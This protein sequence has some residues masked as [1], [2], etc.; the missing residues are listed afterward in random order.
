MG[1][2]AARGI[3]VGL[4]VVL[5]LLLA[6]VLAG[7]PLVLSRGLVRKWINTDPDKFL[8]EYDSAT[9]W[10]PGMV[11]VRGLRIRARDPNVEYFF[12]MEE[13]RVSVSLL[14]L[15]A[16]RFHATHVRGSGLVFRLR[17]RE[18]PEAR[19]R[20][21]EARLPSIPGY[22]DPPLRDSG[23]GAPPDA[24]RPGKPWAVVVE[25]LNV[26]PASEIW[27]E[28]YRFR[29]HARVT[30][31]FALRPRERAQ[32]APSAVDFVSGSIALG[33]EP[34]LGEARGRAS[35]T[36]DPFDPSKVRGNEVWPYIS[37]E[38]RIAGEVPDLAF[39]DHFL[40]KSPEPRLDGGRGP[41]D[42]DVRVEKGVGRGRVRLAA[43][44][45][46][47]RYPDAVIR[48]DA[49]VDGT[50]RGWDFEHD[51]IDLSGTRIELTHVVSAGRHQDSRDWW[52]R[53]DLVSGQV[54]R[55]FSTSVRA[56]CRDARPLFRLFEIGLPGW[57]Q[58]LLTLDG[59]DA[60]A[61]VH[62][63]PKVAEV[64][65]LDA[66]GGKFHLTGDYV[67]RGTERKGGILVESGPLAVGVEM[68]GPKSSLKLLG[69]RKWFE[70]ERGQDR[71]LRTED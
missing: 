2:R 50:V 51:A 36:I 20:A 37:G 13:A 3:L 41:A 68:R 10:P 32:V 24:K 31:G 58:G 46:Q 5:A 26:D 45:V 47:A 65:D 52:G 4:G 38:F 40:R 6:L 28:L 48:A 15:L 53:F 42:A 30:G 19:S 57:A 11:H 18:A 25:G 14:D 17:I 59:L 70:Q 56:H 12:R 21:H 71:G 27:I 43:R 64:H 66:A 7:P 44:A 16:R 54:K 9:S 23:H 22:P 29:G 60:R 55:G 67:K 49:E 61:R 63:A 69:A 33:D 1:S 35:A 8:L 39:L 34:M 62:L